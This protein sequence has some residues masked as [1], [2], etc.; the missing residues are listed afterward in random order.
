[1][2]LGWNVCLSA[3]DLGAQMNYGKSNHVKGLADRVASL[4]H[5]C[6][7][8]KKAM[9]PRWQKLRLLRQAFWPK[10]FFGA[11]VCTLGWNHVKHL[12]T[13]AM[14]ALQFK[15]AGASP[16]LR[17]GLLCHEQCDPGF[18]Q[19]W[20]IFST[21]RRIANERPMFVDLWHSYMDQFNGSLKQGPFATLDHRCA[22]FA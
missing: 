16:A 14:K 2:R 11:S 3:K 9:A 21:F 5:L 10:A 19:A 22:V 4:E 13:E 8:L 17:L 7:K 20:T 6:I 15:K 1:M 12:R 18:Y